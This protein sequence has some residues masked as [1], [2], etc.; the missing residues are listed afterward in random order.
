MAAVIHV[1]AQQAP[2]LRD[3]A[4]MKAIQIEEFGGPEVLRATPRSPDPS[5][6][7]GEVVVNVKRS[8]VNFADTHASRNDYLAEQTLPL[9]PGAEVSGQH[10]RRPPRRRAARQRR[11]RREG[12]GAAGAADRASRRGRLRPGR[13][14]PAAGADRDGAGPPLRPD[15][16]GGDDRRRGR[17][18]R[19]RHPRGAAGQAGRRE[20]DRPRLQRGEAR[21]GRR[22]SAPTPPSTPA[23]R[24]SARR[25]ARPTTASASTPSC[26]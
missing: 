4:P 8:G 15:R 10:Q 13:R 21:A 24:T 9:I 17:R 14:R 16:A 6:K 5:P 25:S 7:L 19:H 26:T 2:A 22:A 23:P 1:T 11:L 20:G 3:S 12:R 18:R